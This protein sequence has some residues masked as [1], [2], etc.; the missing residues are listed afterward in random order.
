MLRE[1]VIL[2]WPD[3]FWTD[4]IF[5]FSMKKT[6]SCI[7]HTTI[8]WGKHDYIWIAQHFQFIQT[9][10]YVSISN[11]EQNNLD[12]TFRSLDIIFVYLHICTH[13]TTR[14][15]KNWQKYILSWGGTR[16][17]TVASMNEHTMMWVFLVLS[18]YCSKNHLS[19]SRVN[20]CQICRLPT[21][22]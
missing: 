12:S 10:W 3:H 8:V 22:Y 14:Y 11:V 19:H 21:K 7:N 2:W 6:H 18:H 9:K 1:T 20:L 4:S 13:F 15:F 17:L 16:K 5:V